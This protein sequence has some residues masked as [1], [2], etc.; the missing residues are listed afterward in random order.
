MIEAVKGKTMISKIISTLRTLRDFRSNPLAELSS[1]ER[2]LKNH[3]VT[4]DS[5]SQS[6]VERIITSYN[7]AKLKQF[8]VPLVYQPSGEWN[9][10]IRNGRAKYLDAL[11]SGRYEAVSSLLVDFFR[12][13]GVLG[14]WTYEYYQD[15]VH[16]S[17]TKKKELINSM[18][19]DIRLWQELVDNDDVNELDVSYIGNPWGY[20][21][22]GN[23]I[24]PNACRHHYYATL[25]KELLGNKASVIL[26][27][28]SGYGGLAY[29]LL[30]GGKP[31]KYIG[32]DLPEVLVIAQYYLMIAMPDKRFLLYGENGQEYISQA[33]ISHFDV[34]LMPNFQLPEMV[35]GS[36]DLVISTNSLAEMGVEVIEE[37]FKQIGRICRRYFFHE[38]SN[39]A[40][41][42]GNNSYEVPAS[43]FPILAG[44]KR[45][46]KTKSLWGGGSGRYLEYLYE[47]R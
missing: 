24:L 20:T 40:T 11:V 1:L 9:T 16:A 29:Y 31:Y 17:R 2:G 14:I 46:Y 32:F 12:N 41:P 35:E 6:V 22:N 30:A 13:S 5:Y 26:E 18:L 7:K 3:I 15:I 42:K 28:G 45:L 39:K 4:E 34:I 38:D 8:S 25:I 36:A 47:R 19:A 33:N 27:I 10:T 44:F 21:L 43:E 37:Y 23:L